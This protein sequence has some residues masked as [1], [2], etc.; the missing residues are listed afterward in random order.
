MTPR[1]TALA[2]FL[3]LVKLV[4]ENRRL[5]TRSPRSSRTVTRSSKA[6]SW[7]PTS[8]PENSKKQGNKI[9]P[10]LLLPNSLNNPTI[11]NHFA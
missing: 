10:L 6:S 1:P 3:S 2:S 11:R 7:L 4:Q 9:P 5:H 8:A